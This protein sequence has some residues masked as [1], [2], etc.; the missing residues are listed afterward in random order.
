MRSTAGYSEP[1][2]RGEIELVLIEQRKMSLRDLVARLGAER[3]DVIRELKD[4]REEGYLTLYG[5]N[6]GQTVVHWN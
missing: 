5:T 3:R 4:L 1:T 6:G 2:L